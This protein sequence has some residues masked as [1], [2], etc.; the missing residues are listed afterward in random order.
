MSWT[1]RGV[2]VGISVIETALPQRR[3]SVEALI[4]SGTVAARH[5]AAVRA[6]GIDEV[7]AVKAGD[8]AEVERQAHELAVQAGRRAMQRADLPPERLDLLVH[9]PSRVPSRLMASET[10]RMQAS[11]K[12]SRATCVSVGDLGCVSSSAAL[13][14]ARALLAANASWGTALITHGA[15][16]PTPGRYRAPVTLNGDAGVAVL[17]TRQARLTVR[18]IRLRSDGR[19]WD[20]FFVDHLSRPWQAWTEAC[21]SEREYSFTLAVQSGK[22][23]REMLDE[24]LAE[25]GAGRDAIRHLLMQNLSLAAQRFY[26]QAFERKI[27]P[28]CA[29]NLRHYGHLGPADIFVNLASV[30]NRARQGELVIVANNSPSAAWSIA[31]LTAES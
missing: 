15:V 7:R 9:I 19:F 28:V 25:I 21:R 12:A 2:G 16:A 11:L 26:E 4:E 1:E 31:A 6:L 17:L 23:L 24:T 13:L 18:D 14:T 20:L 8:P 3:E 5:A 29:L 10:T 22:A 27:S 30:L